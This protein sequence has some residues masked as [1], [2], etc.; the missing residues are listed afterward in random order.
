MVSITIAQIVANPSLRTVFIAGQ[1][2]GERT[3]DWAHNTDVSEPWH[4]L[5]AGELLLTLGRNFPATAEEQISFIENLANAGIA[6]L[7]VAAG[8]YAPELTPEAAKY[9]DE[10]SFPII[11]TA[12]ETPFVLI[13]RYVAEVTSKTN[14]LSKILQMYEFYRQSSLRRESADAQLEA[15]EKHVSMDLTILDTKSLRSIL[16]FKRKLPENLLDQISSALKKSPLPAVFRLKNA[17]DNYLLVSIGSQ[18][19]ILVVNTKTENVDL[20]A[21]Q[22]TASVVAFI[23]ERYSLEAST[24]AT[25]GRRLLT[26]LLENL[27]DR[28]LAK[29]RLEQFGLDKGP[30][31]VACPQ[32]NLPIDLEYIHTVFNRKNIPAIATVGS[33]GLLV[34]T[35]ADFAWTEE[36]L[37]LLVGS[38]SSVGLSSQINS[39]GRLADGAR[40]ANWARESTLAQGIRVGT[41]GETDSLFL[42]RTVAAAE[43][44]VNSILGP[45]LKHDQEHSGELIKSLETF[46]AANMSWQKASQELGIHRQ[47]LNYRMQKVFELTNHNVNNIQELTELHL[48]IKAKNML[49]RI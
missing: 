13:S 34:L 27:V 7:D 28:E 21:L 31:R 10:I 12:Y 47:T 39:L 3:V 17:E 14:Q 8:W 37:N 25:T 48:A 1:S 29:E 24:R 20:V 46:F 18:D 49:D 32:G 33:K 43:I 35:N 44:A 40:E 22:H 19:Q 23:A 4:W 41:Y 6:G 30:W 11:Q 36:F 45:L 26:Q 16:P 15:L 2:G 42:P 38:I 9:A 5:S